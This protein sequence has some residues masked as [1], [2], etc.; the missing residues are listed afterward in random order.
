MISYSHIIQQMDITI[1]NWREIQENSPEYR[2]LE[3]AQKAVVRSY[4][5]S[6]R[7]S[8]NDKEIPDPKTCPFHI[9]QRFYSRFGYLMGTCDK[10]MYDAA[11]RTF[12]GYQG[13][14]LLT[15]PELAN[16]SGS[17]GRKAKEGIRYSGSAYEG[18]HDESWRYNFCD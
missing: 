18:S 7:P 11:N 16:G 13:T 4:H 5:D 10:V 9:G 15:E 14:W 8:L 12:I 2:A 1:P 3:F 6:M 17:I